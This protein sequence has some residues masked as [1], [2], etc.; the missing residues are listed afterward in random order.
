MVEHRTLNPL[1]VGSSPTALTPI[2]RRAVLVSAAFVFSVGACAA[3]RRGYRPG[4]GDDLPIPDRTT[5]VTAPERETMTAGGLRV[6][7]VTDPSSR[8]VEVGVRVRTGHV[9]DPVGKE[10][11]AHLV[12]HLVFELRPAGPSTP[13]LGARLQAVATGVNAVTDVEST[14]YLASVPASSRSRPAARA[15]WPTTR[16][17]T[18]A[19]RCRPTSIASR[20]CRTSGSIG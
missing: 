3:A 15:R 11:L 20:R 9:H 12:E 13:S 4:P 1:V 8:L 19:A 14:H 7:V 18:S 17:T 16:S 2:K 10:G 5:L 6:I